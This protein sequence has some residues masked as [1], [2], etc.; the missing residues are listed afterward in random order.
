MFDVREKVLS[1]IERKVSSG[2]DA[3]ND[4]FILMS[5]AVYLLEEVSGWS[6]FNLV[7]VLINFV[8]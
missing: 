3:S 1:D 6:F 7:E 2:V 8:L 4:T 5:A